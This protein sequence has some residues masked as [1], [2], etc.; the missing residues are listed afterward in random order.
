MRDL[1]LID[2]TPLV[3]VNVSVPL[4]GKEGA[5][6]ERLY[7]ALEQRYREVSVPL[8]GKEGAGLI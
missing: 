3:N 1:E 8:R 7:R 5:G 2:R 6:L 4:R